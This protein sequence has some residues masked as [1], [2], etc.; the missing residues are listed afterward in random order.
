[1]ADFYDDAQAPVEDNLDNVNSE[2]T[3]E[4][5]EDSNE[6]H[7]DVEGQDKRLYAGQFENVEDL[8]KS[9]QHIRQFSTKLAQQLAE[10]RKGSGQQPQQQGTTAPQQTPSMPPMADPTLIQQMAPV[11]APFMAPMMQQIKQQQDRLMQLQLQS[12]VTR[13][14]AENDDFDEVAPVIPELFKTT[15]ELFNLPNPVETAYL[16]AKSQVTQQN[17]KKVYNDAQ[18]AA[19]DSKAAKQQAV[20]EGQQGKTPQKQVSPEE[21]IANSIIEAANQGGSIF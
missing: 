20:T 10:M 6:Q 19:Y 7:V 15:P 21:A 1:M 9:Y 4:H 12:E 14:K 11:L 5:T 17:I 16:L 3:T 2:A 8:E 18:K 13:L